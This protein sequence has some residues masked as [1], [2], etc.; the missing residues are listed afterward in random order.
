MNYIQTFRKRSNFKAI[1]VTWGMD[2]KHIE[3]FINEYVIK[4]HSLMFTFEYEYSITRKGIICNITIKYKNSGVVYRN[5]YLPE[6]CWI[7]NDIDLLVVSEEYMRINFIRELDE[8]EC[9]G[10]CT[11]YEEFDY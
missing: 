5:F 1:Q 11:N 3:D 10:K 4:E 9:F 7:T 6:N 8:P 2:N